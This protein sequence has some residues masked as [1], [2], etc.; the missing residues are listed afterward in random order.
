MADVIY[1]WPS[2][3]DAKVIGKSHERL[4]GTAKATGAAKYTYDV[5]LKNQLIVKS[6]DCPHVP[7]L[8]RAHQARIQSRP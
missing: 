6:L 5:N 8:S 7:P 2:A 4:D 3:K 1:S